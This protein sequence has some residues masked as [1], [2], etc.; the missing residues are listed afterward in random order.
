MLHKSQLL[1]IFCLS[2]LTPRTYPQCLKQSLTH[3][4]NSTNDCCTC[5]SENPTCHEF[6]CLYSVLSPTPWIL[7]ALHFSLE[8]GLAASAFHSASALLS[9][10]GVPPS[11]ALFPIWLSDSDSSCSTQLRAP[12][13][14]QPAK[15][16]FSPLILC[17]DPSRSHTFY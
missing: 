16:P 9:W 1:L 4:K 15:T 8:T 5:D 2:Y 14:T 7:S 13:Q 6:L 17:F 10:P 12:L 11:P 3:R